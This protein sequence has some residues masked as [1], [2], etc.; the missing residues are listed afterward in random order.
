M[1]ERD[2]LLGGYDPNA[3]YSPHAA[4]ARA[5]KIPVP[6][7]LRALLSEHLDP[8][9]AAAAAA[10]KARAEP[11]SGRERAF[12]WMWQA[13]A[14]TLVAA[15]FAAAVAQARSVAPGVRSAQQLLAANVRS[16][17]S[18]ATK[19]ARQRSALAAR[20]DQVQR[21]ALA[22]DAEGQRLL[23]SLDARSLAAASTAVIGP[24]L[25][26]T[27]TDPGAGPNLSD[28]SKQRV[29]GSQQII[30][31]RDLQ[32]VV[33]SLWASGAEAISVDGARIGPNV[34]IRQA[35]GA[36]LV[37]N[38]PTSSPYTILAIGPPKSMRDTFDH[39]PGL[40]RL[41]L[42]EASYGVGVNVNTGDGLALPAGA[43]RDVKFATPIGP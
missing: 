38:N 24:G 15:V 11:E 31:D 43:V 23:N 4:A 25:T 3:G 41:R 34:T 30:L 18:A 26:V 8:G 13:L 40:R 17:Q 22:D 6:S 12:G 36:I 19:L 33:N 10:R 14:A 21:L 2:R 42:L 20:V 35:G 27:V 9:Y 32:L 37:D 29:T 16:T 28:A 39:S 5:Q 7:L 1:A